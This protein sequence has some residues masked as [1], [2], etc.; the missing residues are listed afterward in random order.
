MTKETYLFAVAYIMLIYFLLK[1]IGL[2]WKCMK[3][4]MAMRELYSR[5]EDKR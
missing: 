5:L 4:R 2:E 1:I 3:L